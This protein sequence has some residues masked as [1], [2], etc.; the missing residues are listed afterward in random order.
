MRP[1]LFLACIAMIFASCRSYQINTV[2]SANMRKNDS[3]GVFIVEND[4]LT[5]RYSFSGN[6]APVNVEVFNKLNEPMVINW[7]RSAL[8][9]KDKAYSYVDDNLKITGETSG[10]SVNYAAN[11]N[12]WGDVRYNTGTLNANIK[13]SKNESFLPPHSQMGRSIFVLGQIPLKEIDKSAFNKTTFIDNDGITKI[14]SKTANFSIANSP[15]KFKS[16]LTLYTFKDNQPRPFVN[17]QEF[18]ISNVTKL[19]LNPRNIPQFSNNPG[20]II[21]NSKSTGFAKTMAAVGAIGAVSG[22]AAADAAVNEKQKP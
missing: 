8:V 9:V 20:D 16:Y 17:E 3:T 6:N 19:N 11:R 15:L 12:S 2:S 22:L 5:I 10:S 7:E 13:L 4:S 18:F 21:I 14:Y 1:S